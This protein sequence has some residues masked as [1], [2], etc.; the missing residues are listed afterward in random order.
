MRLKI[1]RHIIL[2]DANGRKQFK[3][4]RRG[5]EEEEKLNQRFFSAKINKTKCN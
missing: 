1:M 5:S 2:Y 4:N 3:T